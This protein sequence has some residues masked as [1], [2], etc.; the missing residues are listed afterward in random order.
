MACCSEKVQ[1]ILIFGFGL[2]LTVFGIVMAIVWPTVADN[3][4]TGVSKCL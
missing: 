2:L 1:K 3:L 4:L